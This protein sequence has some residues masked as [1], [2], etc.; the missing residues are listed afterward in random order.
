MAVE[1]DGRDRQG[2]VGFCGNG[3]L[4]RGVG[5]NTK[6][7]DTDTMASER[8]AVDGGLMATGKM[9]DVMGEEE[10]I[11]QN[12]DSREVLKWA[13]LSIGKSL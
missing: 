1:S 3:L 2:V 7:A 11:R 10:N 5:A 8:L 12:P 6:D 9:L 13:N 4:A